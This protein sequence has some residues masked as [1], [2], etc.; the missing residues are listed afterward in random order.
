MSSGASAALYLGRIRHRRRSR[1]AHAFSYRVWHA[2]LDLDEVRRIGDLEIDSIGNLYVSPDAHMMHLH[3]LVVTT[4][5]YSQECNTIT[6][7]GIHVRLYLEHETG[8]AFLKRIDR[9]GC[10]IARQW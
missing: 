9:S 5:T 7:C 10:G 1:P 4:G 3:A 6:M 2:L 8:K